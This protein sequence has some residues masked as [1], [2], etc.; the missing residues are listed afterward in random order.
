MKFWY[1]NFSYSFYGFEAVKK[2]INLYIGKT[3]DVNQFIR[4][5]QGKNFTVFQNYI[6]ITSKIVFLK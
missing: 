6:K 3:S 2:F 1:K 5:T 4:K